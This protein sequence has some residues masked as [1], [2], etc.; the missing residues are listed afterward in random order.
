MTEQNWSLF[1]DV[2][3]MDINNTGIWDSLKLTT[4]RETMTK[5]I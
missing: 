2:G 1:G 5:G 4:L 3:I